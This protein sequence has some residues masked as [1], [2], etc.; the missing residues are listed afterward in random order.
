MFCY[1]LCVYI[2]MFTSRVLR[3]HS[4]SNDDIHNTGLDERSL[5]HPNEFPHYKYS[6]YDIR[7]NDYK[8]KMLGILSSKELPLHYKLL[9][10][11]ECNKIMD[12]DNYGSLHNG[13]LYDDWNISF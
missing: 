13:G 6:E 1:V 8:K 5:H 11:R 2:I 3:I 12:I 7:V 4:D 9:Y 10:T